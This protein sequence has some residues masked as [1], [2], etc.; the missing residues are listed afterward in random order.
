M[1]GGI[2]SEQICEDRFWLSFFGQEELAQ[3]S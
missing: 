1:C 2:G 3:A